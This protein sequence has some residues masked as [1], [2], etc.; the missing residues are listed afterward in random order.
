MSDSTLPVRAPI[1]PW[2][3]WLLVILIILSGFVGIRVIFD[4]I[5]PEISNKDQRL[6]YKTRLEKDLEAIESSGKPVRLGQLQGKVYLIGY[7]YTKCSRGCAGVA[8]KMREM[9]RQFASEPGFHLVSV[10]LDPAHDSPEELAKYAEAHKLDRRNWWFLTGEQRELHGYMTS[11]VQ[12]S[13]V[14]EIPLK[15]RLSEFDV[16][17]HDLRLALV[18]AGGHI[19][20][21]Y[22]PMI[23]DESLGKLV[24]ENMERDIKSL[25]SEA[26]AAPQSPEKP[27]K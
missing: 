18:D 20:G 17:E 10:S 22:D 26:A 11:Q 7:L 4:K 19:R 12:L 5:V 21:Y 23:G 9:Q 15:D 3:V 25:L 13:P 6:P 16:Y 8:E 14:R 2:T 1:K 27:S 24:M